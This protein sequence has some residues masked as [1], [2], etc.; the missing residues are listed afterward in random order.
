MQFF[1][2]RHGE[3]S[4]NAKTDDA[5]VLTPNGKA[6]ASQ[7]GHWLNEQV[8]TFDLI[9]VSPYVRAQQ[10]W[11]EVKKSLGKVPRIESLTELTPDADPERCAIAV[12]A[13]AQ[14]YQA[15]NTLVIAH[16]PLLGY[17]VSELV[18]DI[19]PP[20]FSTAGVAVVEMNSASSKLLVQHSPH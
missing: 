19:E 1:L 3:A 6:Q 20:L 14:H 9:L 16:M 13:Y 7:I 10:T 12:E 17:L 2:M 8:E 15:K 4:F 5:R 18:S 11:D